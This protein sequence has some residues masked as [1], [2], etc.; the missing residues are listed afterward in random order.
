MGALGAITARAEMAIDAD[1][2]DILILRPIY[3]AGID[4]LAGMLNFAAKRNGKTPV[5]C[6]H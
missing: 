5:L 6:F 4:D 2:A 3:R 1:F